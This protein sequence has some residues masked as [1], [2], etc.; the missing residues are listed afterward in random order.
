M[1]FFHLLALKGRNSLAYRK[2]G[3]AR[4]RGTYAEYHGVVADRVY[5]FFLSHRFAFDLLAARSDCD[6]AAHH[7]FDPFEIPLSGKLDAIY[8]AAFVYGLVG[9]D[10]L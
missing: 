2:I 7:L 8:D 10:Q 4:S 9:G 5:V 1:I 6:D 3:F